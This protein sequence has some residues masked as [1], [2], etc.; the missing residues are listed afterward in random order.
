[1]EACEIWEL[2]EGVAG[3]FSDQEI[4][5]PALVEPLLQLIEL[6]EFVEGCVEAKDACDGFVCVDI[7]ESATRQRLAELSMSWGST[8][9]GGRRTQIQQPRTVSCRH[10]GPV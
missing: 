6:G 4:K 10:T 7:R 5:V 9:I 3:K 2:Q 8:K 1:M